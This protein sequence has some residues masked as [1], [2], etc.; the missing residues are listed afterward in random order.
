MNSKYSYLL[1]GV[2]ITF[3][4]VGALAGSFVLLA[5]GIVF[6]IWNWVVAEA[7]RKVEEQEYGKNNEENK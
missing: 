7:R 5:M 4:F 3:A 6:A 2:N 1:C